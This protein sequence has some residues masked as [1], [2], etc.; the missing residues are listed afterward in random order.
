MRSKIFQ[1]ILIILTRTAV[2]G[3]YFYYQSR[4]A[5][6]VGKTGLTSV[7]INASQANKLTSGLV[8]YW[9]F[10]G[11]DTNWTSATAGTTADKS[12]AGTNT[13][14][15][16]GMSRSTSP[17]IGKV[18]QG[19][20]FDGSN[21]YVDAGNNASLA[22]LGSMTISAWIKSNT[23][24]VYRGIVSKHTYWATP[25]EFKLF[26]NKLMNYSGDDDGGCMNN[27]A[28]TNSISFNQW[29]HVVFVRN[30]SSGLETFYINTVQDSGG[31]QS[32]GCIVD[33]GAVVTIGNAD[34]G[35]FFNGSIDEVRVYN[36]A[37]SQSEITELYNQGQ[38]KINASQADKLTSGLVGH[39]T[40]DGQDTN[41][42]S[43]TAG[44]TADKSPVGTNT[45][46]LNGMSRSTSPAIGKVGQGMYFD[47][48]NDRVDLGN[49]TS[50]NFTTEN[51]TIAF[52]IKTAALAQ[53]ANIF[54][55]GVMN[56]G[57]Y[58]IMVLNTGV[59]HLHTSQ[60]GVNQTTVAPAGTL[61]NNVW[62]HIVV[63]RNGSIGYIYKDGVDV[64]SSQPTIIN[65]ATSTS[66]ASIGSRA[67]AT[68]FINAV[69]DEVRVYNRAL[70]QS[71]IT[72]LYN[73]G[74]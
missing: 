2:A 27:T 72:E 36:R 19:M 74:R 1:Y 67:T 20:Y 21:D 49:N 34:G 9:T 40:F 61:V 60:S 14:T 66:N 43:A 17:A 6:T 10:D 59:I 47:G 35:N 42:T 41:W 23:N 51:F 16:T 63:V 71:E 62:S 58:E 48:T 12:Q 31:W 28:S 64:S 22:L 7:K 25:Y 4:A 5:M 11:Q 56:T 30:S 3:S 45:G 32:S 15:L 24:V 52:W 55:R 44:T 53:G 8:G 13:G 65:P 33:E 70:S 50:L 26:E 39:W 38:V 73:L 18:G 57:G 54:N 29:Q 69:L 46:T 37:L 68:N